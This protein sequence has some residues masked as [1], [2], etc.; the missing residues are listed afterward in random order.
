MANI[1]VGGLPGGPNFMCTSTPVLP[2][3]TNKTTI[4][5]AINAM[6]AQGATGVGEGAAWGWRALSPGAPFTE[7]RPYS[8]KNNTKVLVL[9]T[10]GQNTYYPNS[11]FLKSWY[12]IYGYVDRDHLGTTSTTSS[13]LT[14][15]MDQ[16]TRR[17]ATTSRRP[18]SSSIRWLF[19]FPVTQADALALLDSCA[20]DKD[21]Y[22]APGTEAELLAAFNAIGM[23]ISELRLAH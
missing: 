15:A 16:R 20:S 11:R 23:D 21:K 22:F 18:A 2:L 14:Q 5:N 3:S 7:G 12:D 4:K 13:T 6:V 10:D 1:T 19:K 9:M 17:P 8:T